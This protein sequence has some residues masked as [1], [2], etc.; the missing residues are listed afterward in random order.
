M[1]GIFD[2]QLARLASATKKFK[3][4]GDRSSSLLF[5]KEAPRSKTMNFEMREPAILDDDSDASDN[6][7][8]DNIESGFG[9]AL[10]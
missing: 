1:A 6:E 5:T 9:L 4:G 10:A 2:N 8:E 7:E 3:V